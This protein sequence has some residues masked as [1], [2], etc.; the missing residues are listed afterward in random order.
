MK[1]SYVK[2]DENVKI[3]IDMTQAEVE[4]YAKIHWTPRGELYEQDVKFNE[5][6][7]PEELLDVLSDIEGVILEA[8]K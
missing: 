7:E 5:W 4:R 6:W 8:A 3:T 1:T 2:D